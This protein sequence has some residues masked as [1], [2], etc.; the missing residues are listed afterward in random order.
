MRVPTITKG[1]SNSSYVEIK[2]ILRDIGKEL[3]IGGSVQIKPNKKASPC[4]YCKYMS[5]CRKNNMV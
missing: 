5:I 2:D 3:I 1:S 4:D